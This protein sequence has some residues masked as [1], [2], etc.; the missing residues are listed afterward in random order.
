MLYLFDDFLDFTYIFER[1]VNASDLCLVDSEILRHESALFFLDY[2]VWLKSLTNKLTRRLIAD[3][4]PN[5]EVNSLVTGNAAFN[6]FLNLN[7]WFR[8]CIKDRNPGIIG[9]LNSFCSLL[10]LINAEVSI[11]IHETSHPFPKRFVWLN[12]WFESKFFFGAR[13]WFFKNGKLMCVFWSKNA[14][15]CSCLINKVQKQVTTFFF[16]YTIRCYSRYE[17]KQFVIYCIDIPLIDS[18]ISFFRAFVYFSTKSS[19]KILKCFSMRYLDANN[20]ISLWANRYP[21]LCV[22]KSSEIM[23]EILLVIKCIVTFNHNKLS[24]ATT[25]REEPRINSSVCNSLIC[26]ESYRG[27]VE[28][29]VP[30]LDL[31]LMVSKRKLKVIEMNAM[32]TVSS[33]WGCIH[34]VR[35]FLSSQGSVEPLASRSGKSV[36]NL[37]IQGMEAVGI[38]KQDNYSSRFLYRPAVYSDP[39]F[40]NVTLG[41]VF[42]QA[43][44]VLNDLWI[45]KFRCTTTN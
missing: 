44:R 26:S 27:W 13:R 42:A 8:E 33:E 7:N 6:P 28:E 29:P 16:D 45:T 22:K 38:V 5:W 18:L 21:T 43:P 24:P 15:F 34:N 1:V 10:V 19:L 40:Q 32:K 31:H 23:H 14:F 11:S 4:L 2:K 36:Y 12:S 37:F 41:T 17:F 3:P 39:L 25:K 35:V 30:P 20:N 9:V